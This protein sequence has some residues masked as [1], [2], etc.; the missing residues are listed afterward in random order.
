MKKQK[1]TGNN[2][3]EVQIM[4]LPLSPDALEVLQDLVD[5]SG[6]GVKI[7]TNDGDGNPLQPVIVGTAT[8]NNAMFRRMVDIGGDMMKNGE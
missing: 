4:T 3:G 6:S 2:V 7:I 5:Q 1:I 8:A